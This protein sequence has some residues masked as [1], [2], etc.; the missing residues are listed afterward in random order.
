MTKKCIDS[1]KKISSYNINFWERLEEEWIKVD[2]YEFNL[3]EYWYDLKVWNTLIEI[4]PF[5]FHNETWHPFNKRNGPN[6]HL[7]KTK[8][9]I[10]HWFQCI[11]VFNWDD[12]EKIINILLP[13]QSIYARQCEVKE[14]D[15]KIAN[16]FLN[17]YH[18]QWALRH[19]QTT[20]YLWLYYKNE[21]V[22]VMTFWKPRKKTGCDIELLRLCS[23]K[24]YRIIW[25]AN[26]LFKY[27]VNNYNPKSIISYCD[28]AKF[29]W[30]VY[31]KLW[32][33]LK[34]WNSPS[35]HW[36]NTKNNWAPKHIWWSELNR[37]WFDKL[38]WKYFW[39]F[40]HWTN[41]EE[42]MRQ[43]NYVEIYDAWQATFIRT[44][45]N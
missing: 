40:W 9:A 17:L 41:N 30:D 26:K 15:S 27:F 12:K 31:N 36:R 38:L 34:I 5:A 44:N 32:F 6:Y 29:N 4:N 2:C 21:L 43:H 7:D 23:H 8:N 42:L 3:W 33:N 13:K 22:E 1:S 18:L 14:I 10:E 20:I 19:K 16:Q 28:M 24:D 11:H 35:K 45:N 39:C 37:L 25:W